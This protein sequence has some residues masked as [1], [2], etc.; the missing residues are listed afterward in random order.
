MENGDNQYKILIF[1]I[2]SLHGYCCKPSQRT[3]NRLVYNT[4]HTG[5]R[6]DGY[7]VGLQD[8]VQAQ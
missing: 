8:S 6:A 3:G 7:I 5:G 1:L 4:S 2:D